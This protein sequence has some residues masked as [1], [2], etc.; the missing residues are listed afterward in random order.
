MFDDGSGGVKTSRHAKCQESHIEERNGIQPLHYLQMS[1][2][3]SPRSAHCRTSSSL[4][5]QLQHE[6]ICATNQNMCAH[7]LHH[8]VRPHTASKLRQWSVC[9]DF[10]GTTNSWSTAC[11]VS[12]TDDSDFSPLRRRL[13]MTTAGRSLVDCDRAGL[14]I[15][16][17]HIQEVYLIQDNVDVTL[18]RFL[19]PHGPGGIRYVSH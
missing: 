6:H 12:S 15:P 2:S 10:V 17:G 8:P 9:R 16:Q 4:R 5:S 14:I 18:I 11:D 7:R 3:S 13:L 1:F 19:S